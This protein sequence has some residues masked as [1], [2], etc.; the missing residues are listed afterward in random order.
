MPVEN[1]EQAIAQQVFSKNTEKTFVDKILA[2][3]DIEAVRELIKKPRLTRSELLELLYLLTSTESKLL[4]YGEWDRYII[5]KYFVWVREFIK[6]SELLFDYK[7]F[8]DDQELKGRVILTP[9]SKELLDNCE[10]LIEHNAKF[11]IDL[12]F[13]IARTTLSLG[14]TGILEV[15]KNK[16]EISYPAT[17]PAGLPQEQQKKGFMGIFK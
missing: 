1:F 15:L 4:N 16:Y 7:E 11:L 14:A 9:R 12:Y 10:R 2:R 17:P 3:Q 5:L 8:L 13:N 6:I